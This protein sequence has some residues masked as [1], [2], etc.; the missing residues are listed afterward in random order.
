MDTTLKGVN[1]NRESLE[2]ILNEI[3]KIDVNDNIKM[4]LQNIKDIRQDDIYSGYNVNIKANFDNMKINIMLDVTTGDVITNGEIKYPYVTLFEKEV[5]PIMAYN[6][7]TIIA[8][9]Y[10]SIL[11]RNIDN[12][13][14]KDYYDIYMF[15]EFKWREIDKDVLIKAIKNTSK[16][17]ST[18]DYI[19][20]SKIYI[21]EIEKDTQVR[22]RW[23]NYQKNYIYAKDISFESVI[24][25]LKVISDL[26]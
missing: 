23:K 25:A 1:L 11:S 20:N 17:R 3:I 18:K 6:F 16:R 4:E 12:T 21:N 19:E 5:I 8:E 22:K 7:E 9:K 26:Y 2:K 13:R 10:E 24:V 14:M 15:V